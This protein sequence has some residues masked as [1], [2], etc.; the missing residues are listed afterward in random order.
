[1]K[2]SEFTLIEL[3]VVVAIIAIL[4]ALLLPSL[5]NAREQAY[6][7]QCLGSLKQLGLCNSMYSDSYGGWAIPASYGWNGGNY[8][9][10]WI[11]TNS[12]G[13][14]PAMKA[15]LGFGPG[16]QYAAGNAY[17]KSMIC[18]RAPLATQIS[19]NPPLY[20]V[21]GSYGM[22]G[23]PANWGVEPRG[24]KM[25]MV[26]KPSMLLNFLDGTDQVLTQSHSLYASYYGLYGECYMNDNIR[27]AMTMYRHNYGA[28]AVFHDGH[29]ANMNYRLIQNN[30]LYWNF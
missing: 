7:I 5:K 16:V 22:N 21:N 11:S 9:V 28:D 23:N 27:N 18:A 10:W 14:A 26:P 2:K 25:N 15:L 30:A 13:I 3:L 17:P 12:A 1:M 29:A 4:A 6:K 19:V 24:F 8:D 20:S